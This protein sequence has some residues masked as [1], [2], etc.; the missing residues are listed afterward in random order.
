MN[1]IRL[2]VLPDAPTVPAYLPV[3]AAGADSL[4][5]KRYAVFGRPDISQVPTGYLVE[6]GIPFLNVRHYS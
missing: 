1:N 5:Q 6:A 3:P 2:V 4:T